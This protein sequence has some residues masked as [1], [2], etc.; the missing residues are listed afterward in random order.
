MSDSKSILNKIIL[1]IFIIVCF[2]YLYKYFFYENDIQTHSPIINLV[3][4]VVNENDEIIYLG[5]SSNITFSADDIDKRSISD[6]IS[7]Y[8]P[9]RKMGAITKEATHAGIYYELLRNIPENS[10]VK[11]VIVTLNLRSFDANWIYSNL[12][13]PL[14]KSMVLLKKYPPLYNRFLLSFRGYD[15]KTEHERE[16]QF[17]HKWETDILRF[18]E[19]FIYNNVIDWDRRLAQQGIKNVDGSTNQKQ[20]ELACHYIKTYAFQIDT[21]TN[22]RIKD[23]DK[24]ADLAKERHWNL[25]FNLMAENIE[26]ADS[27][28]GKELVYLLK[29][30]RDLL[31][32][33]Y[34]KNNV[35][36]VDNL[37]SV[38]D[39]EFIDRNW[40][41]EHYAEKGRKIIAK[42]VAEYLKTY[43][44]NDY[45]K[46]T[47]NER[48][49]SEF[50]NDCEGNIIWGQMQTLTSEKSFLGKKSSKIGQK[51][52]FSITF[53]YPIK[54]LPDSLTQ[55]SINL[56]LF[57]NEINAD[58]KLIIEISGENIEYQ[59]N[60]ILI[61]NLS[62]TIQ[63]WNEINYL[64]PIPNN[65]HAGDVIKIYVYNPTN[66]I[67]YI[68]DFSI[69][70][71]D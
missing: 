64:F 71:K 39:S 17:L 33:R 28:V 14:Q 11:T 66:S 25:I 22:P 16:K 9:S 21:L 51:Q 62:K 67:I 3:R 2:N 1:L 47:Y 20:T 31:V 23:F 49:P 38:G 32:K 37:E 27:L 68:D 35:L 48:K 7:D 70:F 59:W 40:T 26:K 45:V 65:F 6:L 56:Q 53:E 24:I 4:N 57:Q 29:Q 54:K 8:Y 46:V 55:I 63:A 30:N 5:E 42:N 18:P 34:N 10:S 44:A 58:A 41:T 12:E 36:V 52:D 50:Y 69:N 43:Y 15:I 19:P 13:T 61:N 60:G